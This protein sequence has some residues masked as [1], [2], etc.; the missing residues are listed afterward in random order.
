MLGRAG[1]SGLYALRPRVVVV[2]VPGRRRW[3]DKSRVRDVHRLGVLE[4]QSGAF[5][6]PSPDF[7]EQLSDWVHDLLV[8]RA[9]V[10]DE[11]PDIRTPSR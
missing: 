5:L 9:G 8:C 3:V 7:S 1:H 6:G 4:R 2:V 11:Q 10:A